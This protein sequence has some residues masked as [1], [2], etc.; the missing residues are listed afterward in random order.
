MNSDY[1][2]KSRDILDE[3]M[4]IGVDNNKAYDYD[5]NT[6]S[7]YLHEIIDNHDMN[8]VEIEVAREMDEMYS[9]IDIKSNLLKSL[10]N[11][12]T[13]QIATL[14]T[15]IQRLK[16]EIHHK[17]DVIR[18]MINNN[19]GDSTTS[20]SS[21]ASTSSSSNEIIEAQLQSLGEEIRALH[22]ENKH[23]ND[24]MTCLF[25]QVN[26]NTPATEFHDQPTSDDESSQFQDDVNRDDLSLNVLS[27]MCLFVGMQLNVT[28]TSQNNNRNNNDIAP[29]E[30]HS[31]GFA[32]RML[33]KKGYNGGGLGKSENGIVN[34]IMIDKGNDIIAKPPMQRANNYIHPWQPNTTLIIGD[35]ILW[36]V[37]EARLKK[38]RAKV[39]VNPGA[40][41]DDIYDYI[42]PLLKKKPSNIILMVGSNDSI[43]KSSE[44]IFMEI[45]NLKRYIEE[46]LQGVNVIISC[47]VVRADNLKANHTLRSLEEKLKLSSIKIVNNDNIDGTCLGG[48][49]LHLNRKGAGRLAINYI[50]LMRRL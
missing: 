13:G 18:Y 42:A 41:V 9:P 26:H 44:Q 46:V 21:S 29:W 49:G 35:S 7:F 8:Q 43:F 30:K 39:R 32:S 11:E 12:L 6:S 40:T 34:P 19:D 27:Y 45:V 4:S 10:T 20:S 28:G 3:L 24:K 25:N 31:S 48:K 47:P 37:E 1:G 17:N 50:S 36:G 15:E 23:L 2:E 16:D 38:Y 14:T 22:K 33:K 5:L